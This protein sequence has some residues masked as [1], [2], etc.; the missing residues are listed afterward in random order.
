[1]KFKDWREGARAKSEGDCCPGCGHEAPDLVLDF[2]K[3]GQHRMVAC[4]ACGWT[5]IDGDNLH[6]I[7]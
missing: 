7:R 4:L 3:F 5:Y 6:P 2:R 1:M